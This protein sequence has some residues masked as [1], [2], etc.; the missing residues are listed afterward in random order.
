MQ[1]ILGALRKACDQYSLI[2]DGDKICVGISGGKDSLVLLKAM[3]RFQTFSPNKFSLQAVAIDLTNGKNDYSK[4]ESF[5]KQ[6]NVPLEI[7]PSNVFEIVFDIRKEKNPCSL[8]ANMRRGL[9]NSTAKRLNCNKVALGHHKDDLIETFIIS[10]FF[11]G[12][13]STFKPKSYLSN[14]NIYAIRPLIFCNE[15]DIIQISEDLPILKNICPADK[16][17]KREQAKS[18]LKDLDTT[19]PNSR[20]KIFNAIIHQERYNLFDKN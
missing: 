5:C 18:I 1:K 8:C 11:E 9:L 12:R 20:E 7:V 14:T 10:L 4:I 3:A 17:T 6:L 15:S 19:Y 16:H 13:L 2:E